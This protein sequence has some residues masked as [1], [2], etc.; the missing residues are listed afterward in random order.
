MLLCPKKV[1]KGFDRIFLVLAI[2]AGISLGFYTGSEIGNSESRETY[3]DYAPSYS[4]WHPGET[5]EEKEIREKQWD[6]FK[7]AEPLAHERLRERKHQLE[8][9]GYRVYFVNV[10]RKGIIVT[11]DPNADAISIYPPISRCIFLGGI[12]AGVTFFIALF[13]LRGIA[14]LILWIK[15]GFDES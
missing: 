5:K 14:L 13:F 11:N 4:T 10:S 6:A 3:F 8:N 12:F 2:I 1:S 7:K 15:Q 9:E